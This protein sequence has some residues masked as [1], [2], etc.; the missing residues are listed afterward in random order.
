M[1]LY[2][3]ANVSLPTVRAHGIQIVKTCEGLSGAG[4]DVELV[5]TNRK[6][7]V[8]ENT[9]AYYGSKENFKITKLFCIDSV[10]LGWFGFWFQMFTFVPGVIFYTL[11]KNGVFL[12]RDEFLA[13]V[14]K[15]LGKEVVWE[16]H[17]GQRNIFAKF[18][19]NTNAKIIAIS[20]GIQNLYVQMGAKSLNVAVI[21]DGVDINQFN[22]DVSREEARSKVGIKSDKKLVVYVGSLYKWKGWRTLEEAKQ[23]LPKDIEVVVIS[24]RMYL[25]VP[26]CLKAAD[27]L[28]IPN[29]DKEDVSRLYT[30]PMKLF[31]YM[32]SGRPIVASDL[33]SLREVLNES[34]CYFFTP[35]SSESL[36]QTIN[37]VLRDG[38]AI[39]KAKQ[40]LKDVEQY[41]WK[42]RAKEIIEYINAR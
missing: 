24:N 11:F 13:C 22:I 4:L 5:V 6:T 31:E 21:P 29:S 20:H 1:K 3:V 23:F 17:T 40:A 37:K 25:E 27:V 41:S 15:L 39:K 16:A 34:N 7:P 30:S 18:L 19:I 14:L 36:A 26:Y 2:Y 10:H 33:P 32:A 28:V 35:D 12:T 9:F 38:S 8:K 42:K